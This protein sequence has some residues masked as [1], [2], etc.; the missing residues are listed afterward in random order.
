M[1]VFMRKNF[2][3]ILA[4]ISLICLVGFTACGVKDPLTVSERAWL[5]KKGVLNI[6]VF[7]DYPPFGFLDDTKRPVGMSID[8]W[9]L[10]ARKLA[11]RA[12]RR[13]VRLPGRDLP[14]TGASKRL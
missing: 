12:G 1:E 6:G 10:L 14:L 7:E 2:I 11:Q 8:Y 13:P 9:N 5:E 4:L 3:W